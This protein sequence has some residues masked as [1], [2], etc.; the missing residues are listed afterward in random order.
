MK[1]EECI[2]SSYEDF[3]GTEVLYCFKLDMIVD[4]VDECHSLFE[5]E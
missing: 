4:D 5:E 1:C 2:Y 3:D